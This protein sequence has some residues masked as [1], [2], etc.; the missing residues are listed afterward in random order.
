MSSYILQTILFEMRNPNSD[1][2]F[3]QNEWD[4]LFPPE[5]NTGDL[6]L[7]FPPVPITESSP[8]SNF[9]TSD[10]GLGDQAYHPYSYG[11]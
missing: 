11:S 6:N 1:I 9:D 3:L 10:S 7:P 2:L 4:K 5:I 8:L